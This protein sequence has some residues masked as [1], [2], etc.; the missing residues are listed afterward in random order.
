MFLPRT[1]STKRALI[2]ALSALA[3][4]SAFAAEPAAPASDPILC[5]TLE[6][7]HGQV[8][9]FDA[10]RTQSLSVLPKTGVP[11]G[12]WLSVGAGDQSWVV[13]RH[14]D[15]FSLH[16]A[17]N[18]F[19]QIPD[20]NLD[21]KRVGDAFVLY[22]G[23]ALL[24]SRGG[25]PEAQLLTAN[26]RVRL[27]QGMALVIYAPQEEETQVISLESS[28]TLENRY[29]AGTQVAVKEGEAS[30]LNF[31]LLRVQPSHPRAV[32]LVSLREKLHRFPIDDQLHNEAIAAAYKRQERKF[33]TILTAAPA[34][35]KA[36]AAPAPKSPVTEPK[37]EPA[38]TVSRSPASVTPKRARGP[39]KFPALEGGE[40]QDSE[41]LER[42]RLL[43]EMSKIKAE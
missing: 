4:A 20:N 8:Q 29:Q 42:H 43:Q 32:M 18:T 27:K 10:S 6:N 11:C 19:I 5:G 2:A 34:G 35:S 41:T 28:A 7:A 38:S 36:P 1:K 25:T 3:S 12:A 30:S 40:S 37:R 31:K 17:A 22:R 15:G 33:A 21:G 39:Q 9:M 24:R 13:F 26:A 16:A 14:R 23:E